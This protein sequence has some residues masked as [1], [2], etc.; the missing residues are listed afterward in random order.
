M[1][2][3]VSSAMVISRGTGPLGNKRNDKI[4]T[5]LDSSQ[6]NDGWTWTMLGTSQELA[7]H[8]NGNFPVSF[9]RVLDRTTVE[10]LYAR[11]ASTSGPER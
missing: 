5:S 7:P 1:A 8:L 3:Q 2:K 11:D 10:R 4:N 6:V 9:D